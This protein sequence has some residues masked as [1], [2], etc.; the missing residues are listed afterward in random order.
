MAR[1]F[2]Q[3][4]DASSFPKAGPPD[5]SDRYAMR[6][7]LPPPPSPAETRAV[8]DKARLALSAAKRAASTE[9]TVHHPLI[10]ELAKNVCTVNGALRLRT[11]DTVG[12]ILRRLKLGFVVVKKPRSCEK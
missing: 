4:P 11:V 1:E 9:V 10:D 7:K 6:K 3:V 8:R 5:I 2:F 12:L